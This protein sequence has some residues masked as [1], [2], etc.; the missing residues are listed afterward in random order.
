MHLPLRCLSRLT[1]HRRVLVVFSLY[2][3]EQDVL[4]FLAKQTDDNEHLKSVRAAAGNRAGD[5][6]SGEKITS[7]QQ[8]KSMK[9]ETGKFEGLKEEDGHKIQDVKELQN[10]PVSI[11]RPSRDCS[12]KL[13]IDVHSLF[14]Q[15]IVSADIMKSPP[16]IIVYAVNP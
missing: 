5:E 7:K 13:L 14:S 11:P 15:V 16:V 10:V 9:R 1:L 3:S 2:W 8:S 12:G 4:S 6:E